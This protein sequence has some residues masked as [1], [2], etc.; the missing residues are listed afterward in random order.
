MPHQH[1]S[2]PFSRHKFNPPSPLNLPSLPL[3][4]VDF[5]IPPHERPRLH[6]DKD[7]AKDFLIHFADSDAEAK[8]MNILQ[9]VSNR[10]TRAIQIDVDD[11]LNY[12]D[13]DEEFLSRVTENTRRYIGV[14]A[15][16]DELTD[17]RSVSR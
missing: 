10:K 15:V 1:T 5:I 7:I 13:V 9:D 8:Y 4:T 3:I 2:L 12:K 6:P 11:L 14:F 16:I 17:P